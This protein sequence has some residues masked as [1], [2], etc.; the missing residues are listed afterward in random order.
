[1]EDASVF[2]I[3]SVIAKC[4]VNIALQVLNIVLGYYYRLQV[5]NKGI[6]RVVSYLT[7]C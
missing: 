2:V 4:V 6:L 3:D 1:M 5:Y 7:T